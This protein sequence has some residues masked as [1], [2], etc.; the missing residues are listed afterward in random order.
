[1]CR[2]WSSG[3]LLC[4]AATGVTFTGTESLAT[5]RSS[6]WAERGFCKACGSSLFYLLK[7]TGQYFMC[8]GAFDDPSELRLTSEIYIDH[9]PEGYAFAGEHPRLTEAEVLAKFAP[10]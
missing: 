1:M 5:Y 7:P 3:A 4:A 9:K 10:P 6:A 2:R 8:V